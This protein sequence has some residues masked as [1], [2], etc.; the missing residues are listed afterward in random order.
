MYNYVKYDFMILNKSRKSPPR[1]SKWLL[2]NIFSVH[3]DEIC[4]TF[5][6]TL[7]SIVVNYRKYSV[8][9][10]LDKIYKDLYM[11]DSDML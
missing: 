7:I 1:K 4:F 2:I 6:K 5:I 3:D 10:I 9:K 8:H 11:Y